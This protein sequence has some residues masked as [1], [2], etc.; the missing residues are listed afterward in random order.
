MKRYS[1][2][3][4]VESQLVRKNLKTPM[5]G[6][7]RC[8]TKDL[9]VGG[10]RLEWPSAWECKSCDNCTGWIYNADC[11]LKDK[12]SGKF[13]HTLNDGVMIKL[14]FLADR[15]K[16]KEYFARVVWSDEGRQEKGYDAGLSFVEIDGDI[17]TLL[18][19]ERF[20]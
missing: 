7:I 18:N 15:T 6:R 9:S 20:R 5:T 2:K 17:K 4:P 8:Q 10:V 14:R 11:R 19:Y 16:D 12:K 13:D 3:I 1:V